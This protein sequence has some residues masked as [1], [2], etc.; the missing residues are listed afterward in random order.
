MKIRQRTEG[1]L[2]VESVGEAAERE[3]AQAGGHGYG[4]VEQ[5]EADINALKVML[6]QLIDVVSDALEPDDIY[7][8]FDREK[9]EQEFDEF[10]VIDE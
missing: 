9:S 1:G 4:Q 7:Y 6:V 10:E 8:L 5:L 3:L 2:I